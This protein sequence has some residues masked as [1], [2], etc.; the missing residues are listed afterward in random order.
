MYTVPTLAIADAA[1]ITIFFTIFP[2]L[3]KLSLKAKGHFLPLK[4]NFE[5]KANIYQ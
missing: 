3:E 2:F 4:T 1:L 5:Q